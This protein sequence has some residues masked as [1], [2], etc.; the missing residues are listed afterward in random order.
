MSTVLYSTSTRVFSFIGPVMVSLTMLEQ[1]NTKSAWLYTQ[2]IYA[3]T[4][5]CILP[6]PLILPTKEA[7]MT[8]PE[9]IFLPRERLSIHIEYRPMVWA[10][11]MSASERAW[12][13]TTDVSFL[14]FSAFVISTKAVWTPWPWTVNSLSE[15]I[16]TFSRVLRVMLPIIPQVACQQL[17][18]L[19]RGR[20]CRHSA[21][22]K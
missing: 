5:H 12:L 17:R 18:P 21:S 1:A 20:Y 10:W 9:I 15:I 16:S 13:T 19:P 7:G 11:T 2:R 3:R 6:M 8:W 4:S 14:A 22:R